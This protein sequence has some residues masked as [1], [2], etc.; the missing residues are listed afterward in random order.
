MSKCNVKLSAILWSHAADVD[1]KYSPGLRTEIA[2]M[3]EEGRA[4]IGK[5]FDHSAPDWAE[6]LKLGFPGLKVRADSYTQDTPFYRAERRAAAAMMRFLDRLIAE[7]KRELEK[8]SLRETKWLE[9]EI[10]SLER[11]RVGRR[12]RCST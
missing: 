4:S 2:K 3:A 5:D 8:I 1:D 7:G 6:I 11:L 10:A 12:R 9:K